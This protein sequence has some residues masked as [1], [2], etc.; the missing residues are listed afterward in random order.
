MV[1]NKGK[2]CQVHNCDKPAFC[3]GY[4]TRHYQQM[5]FTGR[6]KEQNISLSIIGFCKNI[7]CGKRV[8]ARGLCQ[9]CYTKQRLLE[10]TNDERMGY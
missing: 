4:C 10:V 8:F 9:N 5:K 2:K 7:G 3:K 6:I 1:S